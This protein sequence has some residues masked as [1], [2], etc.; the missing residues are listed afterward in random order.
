MGLH[1]YKMP[2]LLGR[3]CMIFHTTHL[4]IGAS[5]D[6]PTGDTLDTFCDNP[7]IMLRVSMAYHFRLTI[8]P[9]TRPRF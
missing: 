7:K 4:G 5:L 8:L 6:S 1:Q 9:H 3:C 2:T